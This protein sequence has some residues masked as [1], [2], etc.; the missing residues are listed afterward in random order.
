M[1]KL[2]SFGLPKFLKGIQTSGKSKFPPV[3]TGGIYCNRLC[4]SAFGGG[5]HPPV[6]TGGIEIGIKM[7]TETGLCRAGVT[8]TISILPSF[9]LT[10]LL[11]LFNNK[12]IILRRN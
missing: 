2:I 8:R 11:F 4:L 3:K 7:K 9:F 10:H 6:K 5:F 12:V 1:L